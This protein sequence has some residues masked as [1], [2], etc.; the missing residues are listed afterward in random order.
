MALVMLT[1]QP[2]REVALNSDRKSRFLA[3]AG[4]IEV[5]PVHSD[6][7][8]RW[9]TDKESLL[10]AFTPERL[11][12]LAGHQFNRADFEFR[13]ARAGFVDD[14]AYMLAM[15]MRDEFENETCINELYMDS[16][17]T[18]FSAHM[19]R[20]YSSLE[21]QR[22]PVFRGGLSVRAWK[23]VD[24]YIQA[25]LSNRLLIEDLALIAGLSPSHFIRAFRETAGQSPHQY[26][27]ALRLARA[28]HL[29][30]TTES[31]LPE[32]AKQTGFASHSHMSSAL[33]RHR[34]KTPTNLRRRTSNRG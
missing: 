29:I 25:R 18:V 12:R 21:D 15:M 32:I 30:V 6:L 33:R 16:L 2:D 26:I 9:R 14:R 19:L 17:V 5:V 27:L 28:E 3:P 11:Q 34:S 31:P 1:P 20:T 4:A 24:D 7:Y 10:L 23:R 22:L 13:P 8:A